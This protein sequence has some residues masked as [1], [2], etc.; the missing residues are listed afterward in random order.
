MNEENC[1]FSKIEDI[2]NPKKNYFED[3]VTEYSSKK[4]HRSKG[5]SITYFSCLGCLH[6]KV[7]L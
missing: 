6:K 4:E 1:L 5:Q 2:F 3:M 7:S